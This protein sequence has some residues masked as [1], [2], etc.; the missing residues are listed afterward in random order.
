MPDRVLRVRTY[1]WVAPSYQLS[2][3]KGMHTEESGFKRALE[4]PLFSAIFNRRT[5]RVSK[6]IASIPAGSL[7]YTS[8]QSAQP[9][10]P[11]EEALLIAATG[12]TGVPMHDTPLQTETGQDITM[13]V[14]LNA[15]GRSASSPDNAQATHFFLLNDE[16]TYLLKQPGD[17]DPHEFARSGLTPSR[18]ID[19][20]AK[21]KVKVSDKRLDF[22]REYPCYIGTNRYLSNLPGSTIL[23]PVVDMTRYYINVMLFLMG[24]VQPGFR[25]TWIDDWR[26]YRKAGVGKWERNGFL[27]P[28]VPPIPLGWMGT[29]RVHIEADLLIQNL[30]LSIQAM[31]L[32]GWVHAGFLGPLLLGDPDYTK[33]GPGLKFR[34][35]TPKTT[36]GRLLL[37]L[38]TPLP[39][40]RPNP[41]G[42]DGIL[43]GFCPPYFKDMSAAVDAVVKLKEGP[44]GIYNQADRDI[45][46]VYKPGLAS[47]FLRNVPRDTPDAIACAKDICNYIFDTYGRFP[48]HVDAMH[49]PG[50]WVQAHHLDLEY[51]DKMFVGGYTSTQAEHQRLWHNED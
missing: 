10:S 4:Y 25:S 34:F 2:E 19:Y 3:V 20:A 21:C 30:L 48:A 43:E 26:F 9:L 50:V 17:V 27:N 36:L 51:Y 39:A 33:Y 38:V 16:G 22:P 18:L 8:T 5:R 40:W 1:R 37:R 45:E 32:G 35:A 24:Q 23:V 46:G 7:S 6:G 29:F 28:N 14:M 41:V 31:G 47:E 13:T 44:G 11:L 49:V 42:L 12:I 15:R